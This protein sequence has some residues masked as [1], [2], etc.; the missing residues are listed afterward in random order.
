MGGGKRFLAQEGCPP[1]RCPFRERVAWAS[2]PAL[3]LA[4]VGAVAMA[5]ESLWAAL[6]ASVLVAVAVSVPVAYKP[7]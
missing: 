3:V 6:L 5:P 1:T 7:R 2:I 4:A